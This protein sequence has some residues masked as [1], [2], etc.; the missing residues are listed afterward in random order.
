MELPLSRI[1]YAECVEN[2]QGTHAMGV[3]AF[4]SRADWLYVP[5]YFHKNAVVGCRT[6]ER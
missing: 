1:L 2:I 6:V 4:G 5:E 3:M